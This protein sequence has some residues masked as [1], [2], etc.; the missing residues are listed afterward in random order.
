MDPA[1]DNPGTDALLRRIVPRIA[2]LDPGRRLIAISGPP[3]AGKSTLAQA[4]AAARPAATVVPMDGFHL[5]NSLLD[6]AGL[7]GQKGAPRPLTR[8]DLSP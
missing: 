4:L 5:D 1:E 6:A 2:Q 3:A 7:R 8:P